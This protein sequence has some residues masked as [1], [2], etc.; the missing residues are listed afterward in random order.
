MLSITI[1]RNRF[2]MTA[3]FQDILPRLT[4]EKEANRWK[5][6]KR[7]LSLRLFVA[8]A[9]VCNILILMKKNPRCVANLHC[10]CQD[11]KPKG[12]TNSSFLV[13]RPSSGVHTFKT[14]E[15]HLKQS[16][17]IARADISI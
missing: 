3:D 16:Q 6:T 11:L 15:S 12:E 9:T 14:V 8:M 4:L 17:A 10:E 7:W 2:H 1:V 5:I 13:L